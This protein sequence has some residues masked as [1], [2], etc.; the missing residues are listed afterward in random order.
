MIKS[1]LVFGR[2]IKYNNKLAQAIAKSMKAPVYL[3]TDRDNIEAFNIRS[4]IDSSTKC[5]ITSAICSTSEFKD[6][7]KADINIWVDTKAGDNNVYFK[8]PRAFDYR[9]TTNDPIKWSKSIL[10]ELEDKN[11]VFKWGNSTK[12]IIINNYKE[13]TAT[14]LIESVSSTP[15]TAF[16]IC[17]S[18][19]QTFDE[20]K[21][22][23]E[24][25]LLPDYENK[26]ILIKVPNLK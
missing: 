22:F 19:E 1:I 2:N 17:D 7:V 23:I 8:E 16:L 26:F 9:V 4:K 3:S 6:I 18:Y 24:K 20:A 13:V 21:Y 15:Q 12:G 5:L 25:M 14:M 11:E 10:A